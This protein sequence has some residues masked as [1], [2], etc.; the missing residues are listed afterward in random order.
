MQGYDGMTDCYDVALTQRRHA[1]LLQQEYFTTKKALLEDRDTFDA[2][3][4]AFQPDM[5]VH[6]AA[7]AGV[8][9]SI[10]HPRAFLDANITGTFNANGGCARHLGRRH[11]ATSAHR[12]P[13]PDRHPR[14]HRAFRHLVSGLS[15]QIAAAIITGAAGAR[16]PSQRLGPTYLPVR[17]PR[18]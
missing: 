2:L 9:H 16:S 7:H 13:A 5:I 15:R 4:D 18:G 14:G 1:M 6:M 8:R 17:A 10:D 12:L 3:A 11:A